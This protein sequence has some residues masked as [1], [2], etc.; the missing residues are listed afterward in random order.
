MGQRSNAGSAPFAARPACTCLFPPIESC[1][2]LLQQHIRRA[3]PEPQQH[4]VSFITSPADHPR[5]PTPATQLQLPR[6]ARVRVQGLDREDMGVMPRD[7]AFQIAR[8]EGVDV[9]MIT[10]DA[11]PPVCRLISFSKF[12]YEAE[13]AT[14]QRQK[15]SKGC[16]PG[17]A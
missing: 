9:V 16:V 14:K 2:L 4:P 3:A 12:K 8:E 10:A 11:D 6:C 1:P 5:P 17:L 13:R 15:A 7:E